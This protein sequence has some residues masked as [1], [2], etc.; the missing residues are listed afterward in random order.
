MNA[1]YDNAHIEEGFQN[2]C[3]EIQVMIKWDEYLNTNAYLWLFSIKKKKSF[4]DKSSSRFF[5]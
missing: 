1:Q 3:I 2:V 4:R 5:N